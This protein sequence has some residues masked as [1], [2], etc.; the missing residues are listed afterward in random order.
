MPAKFTDVAPSGFWEGGDITVDKS[1][2]KVGEVTDQRSGLKVPTLSLHWEGTTT[3]EASPKAQCYFS[4][5]SKWTTY[6]GGATCTNSDTGIEK[7]F[8]ASTGMGKLISRAVELGITPIL[9][10][11]GGP[12][13]VFTASVW[14]GLR[15]TMA[16]PPIEDNPNARNTKR[17]PL[18]THYLG[19]IGSNVIP[20]V[21]G[22]AVV[23]QLP[24]AE[25][26][27]QLAR[28]NDDYEAFK[29][30]ALKI[31]GVSGDSALV[32]KVV[33]QDGI[34]SAVRATV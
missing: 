31:P 27:E 30:A 14:E 6:D 10:E 7:L 1:V 25:Q 28:D 13:A 32:I 16:T 8:I 20:T 11:R 5:G 15:F 18:P 33:S 9:D 17:I 26:V 19:E 4:C 23:S 2:W 21:I 34:W 29:A 12:E 22:S 24:L 3:D